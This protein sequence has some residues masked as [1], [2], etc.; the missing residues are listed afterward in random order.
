MTN[1]ALDD[2]L[3]PTP[4]QQPHRPDELEDWLTDLRVNLSD[5]PPGWVTPEED[6]ANPLPEPASAP[7]DED[8]PA[9]AVGRHRAADSSRPA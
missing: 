9:Q 5:D 3:D 1:A 4:D 2:S 7:S 6:G 8:G